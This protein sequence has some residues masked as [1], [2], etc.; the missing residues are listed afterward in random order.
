MRF[1]HTADWHLGRIFH[2]IHLTDDQAYILEQLVALVAESKPDAV[3]IA[4]DIYDRAVPPPEAVSLLDEVL[5]RILLDCRVPVIVTAGN[6]DS[7][8]R[9]GFG[10]RVMARQGL[11]VFGQ[12]TASAQ[13]VVISDNHGPVYVCPLPYAEPA[14]VRER[15]GDDGLHSHE[16]ALAAMTALIQTKIPAGSR[17]VAVAHAF[18]AGG[19]GSESE[20]PLSIGGVET[21]GAGIFDA[22]HYVALGHLHQ[23]QQV[24]SPHI[25]YA[26][27]LLKYSFAE[28]GQHKAVSLVE[29]DDAGRAAVEEV[30]LT[31]RR[32]ARRLTG[33]LADIL[34]A[35]PQDVN[36]E[37]Y[38][39]VTLKDSGAIL[40]PMNRLRQVYPNVLHLEK[41]E[42]AGTLEIQAGSRDHRRRSEADL[43]AD[44]FRQVADGPMSE[45]ETAAC[46]RLLDEFSRR[47]REAI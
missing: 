2:N 38:I 1:L 16:Q 35:G 20:R 17:R 33:Y 36:R 5:S 39:M 18:L 10:D 6:H 12:L 27:S 22:F 34:A 25:R 15:L 45:A 43:F 44:F 19:T 31:P 14:V 30:T 4:G 8:E 46:R 13:P 3:I 9:L 28:A 24:V 41:E 7:P 23:A 32:D 29:I 47:E 26:G 42:L 11:H 40:D 21:V 37:D